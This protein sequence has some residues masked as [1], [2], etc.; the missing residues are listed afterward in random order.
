[1][2][3]QIMKRKKG[4]PSQRQRVGDRYEEPWEEGPGE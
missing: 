4:A 3:K 2:N 1:V